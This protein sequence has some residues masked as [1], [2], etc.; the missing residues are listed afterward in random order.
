MERRP[1]NPPVALEP[2]IEAKSGPVKPAAWGMTA[3]MHDGDPLDPDDDD[4]IEP[5]AEGFGAGQG[6]PTKYRRA[7]DKIARNLRLMGF[8]DVEIAEAFGVS[9]DCF[10]DW[11]REHPSF[12]YAWSQGGPVADAKITRALYK[13]AMGYS[14][15]DTKLWYNK[16]TG[17]VIAHEYIKYYPPDTGALEYWLNNKQPN[18]WKSRNSTALT[19]AEGKNLATPL[20]PRINVM[21]IE[22]PRRG[23]TINESGAV[24][25]AE[26]GAV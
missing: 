13:R 9:V 11:R 7:H 17:Q 20:P 23:L 16:D 2:V 15:P 12:A 25:E 14:H 10:S 1:F 18:L 24:D 21:V 5:V 3:M 19:D 4:W 6:R 22:G 8:K 26:T